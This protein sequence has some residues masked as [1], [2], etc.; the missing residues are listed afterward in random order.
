VATLFVVG[1]LLLLAGSISLLSWVD[2][3]NATAAAAGPPSEVAGIAIDRVESTADTAAVAVVRITA[4]TCEGRDLGTGFVAGP[5][6]MILTARHVIEGAAS[7]RV[8]IG[9]RSTTASVVAVDTRRDVAL[10]SAPR[11]AD[12]APVAR[13]T[14]PAVGAV[15]RAFGYPGG[16]ALVVGRGAVVGFVDHGVLALDGHRIM[17]VSAPVAPGESGGPVLDAAD[18][19][20]GLAIGVETNTETGLVVPIDELESLLAGGGMTPPGCPSTR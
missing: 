3:H 11:F 19:V 20:V 17:T 7:V 12:L 4:E 10:L 5:G 1:V 15:V 13:G 18:H 16:G 8:E 9:G 14:V 2:E 6:G